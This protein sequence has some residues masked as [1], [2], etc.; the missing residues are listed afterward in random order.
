M[1]I[2]ACHSHAEQTPALIPS[3][4]ATH[5]RKSSRD[6]DEPQYLTD[7]QRDSIDSQAKTTWRDISAAI[8]QLSKAEQTRQA[9]ET[10]LV[11]GRRR[12]KGFGAL[13]TWAAGGVEKERS[14]GEVEEDE[15]AASIAACREGVVWY[16]QRGLEECGMQQSSSQLAETTET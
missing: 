8:T 11:K 10:A 4:A 6:A 5:A 1:G 9:T 3:R 14:P 13:G 7:K 16:L 15:K 2:I 12:K